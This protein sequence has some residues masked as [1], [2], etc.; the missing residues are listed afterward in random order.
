MGLALRTAEKS[1]SLQDSKHPDVSVSLS[2][3]PRLMTPARAAAYCDMS[4]T[5]F[6]SRCPV[7]PIDFGDKRLDRY[8][9]RDIDEWIDGLRNS[10]AGIIS[11]SDALAE[12]KRANRRSRSQEPQL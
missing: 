8:D 1:L 10:V 4:L 9:R 7:A 11:V 5:A 3:W 12:F 2:G 6:R